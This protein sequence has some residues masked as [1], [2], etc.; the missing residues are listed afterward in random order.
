[1]ATDVSKDVIKFHSEDDQQKNR[2]V[3][4]IVRHVAKVAERASEKSEPE[5]TQANPLDVAL[6]LVGDQSA[7]RDQRDCQRKQGD[8]EPVPII[9]FGEREQESA[10]NDDE[11]DGS[12]PKQAGDPGIFAITKKT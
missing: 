1:M 6:R 12:F 8:I 5:H 4:P 11:T 9:Q 2:A 7:D 10:D 3:V